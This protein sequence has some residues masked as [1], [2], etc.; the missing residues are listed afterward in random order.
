MRQ[1]TPRRST[2]SISTRKR[3]VLSLNGHRRV[4]TQRT[5]IE[6]R[7]PSV[8]PRRR[9]TDEILPPPKSRNTGLR[10]WALAAIHEIASGDLSLA[11]RLR[12]GERIASETTGKRRRRLQAVLPVAAALMMLL[13]TAPGLAAQEA[14]GGFTAGT[15]PEVEFDPVQGPAGGAPGA[16]T[17]VPGEF[18]VGY[19]SE[20]AFQAAPTENVVGTFPEVL[21]QH[22]TFPEVAG[23]PAA[24]EAKRQ[25]LSAQP[26]VVYAEY[27]CAAQVN[28]VAA[29]PEAAPAPPP[30]ICANCGK[31]V[32][33]K[34]RKILDG[35]SGGKDAYGAALEAART[36]DADGSVALASETESGEEDVGS[37]GGDSDTGAKSEEPG[38]EE[39]SGSEEEPADAGES[40]GEGSA[41]SSTEVEPG[42][43]AVGVDTEPV[44]QRNVLSS[45][46]RETASNPSVLVVGT[47]VLLLAA[48]LFVARR[49][50]GK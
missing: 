16:C 44:S 39:P 42:E 41:S 14:P 32:V 37:A 27:N 2:A 26:G 24:E 46:L 4:A 18:L 38:S 34:A 1:T 35:E 50:L 6:P 12:K 36:T 19:T 48:G 11:R 8:G 47:G 33:E 5:G 40:T 43:K 25:E 45:G 9:P 7:T 17:H 49:T 21:A 28:Q 29:A 22:L 3:Q 15:T 30:A 23:D 10:V 13:A 31:Y 20:E